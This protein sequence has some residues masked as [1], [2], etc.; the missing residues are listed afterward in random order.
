MHAQGA[1]GSG[2]NA[3]PIGPFKWPPG[4]AGPSMPDSRP[5]DRAE[6]RLPSV[7]EVSPAQSPAIF[8]FE[9]ATTSLSLGVAVSPPHTAARLFSLGE[10]REPGFMTPVQ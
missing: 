3:R 1:V 7:K 2:D 5:S 10:T 8:F 9:E 6:L 4:P